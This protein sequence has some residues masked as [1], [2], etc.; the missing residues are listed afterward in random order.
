M[1]NGPDSTDLLMAPASKELEQVVR[2]KKVV[3]D[4]PKMVAALVQN[5]I[6]EDE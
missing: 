2:A 3:G 1:M 6:A 5:W 4:D